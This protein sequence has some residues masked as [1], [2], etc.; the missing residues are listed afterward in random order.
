MRINKRIN[1]FFISLILVFSVKAVNVFAASIS[2]KVNSLNVNKQSAKVDETV[3]INAS[4]TGSKNL[5]YKFSIFDGTRW[6]VLQD[7]SSK[8]NTVW[9]PYRASTSKIKLE[10]KDKYSSKNYNSK[11]INYQ[12]YSNVT[13]QALSTDVK[14]TQVINAPVQVT[15]TTNLS[16]GV[17]YKYSVF[18]GQVWKTVRDYTY[19]KSMIW[20]ALKAG[21]YIIKVDVKQA[22]SL[23]NPDTSTQTSIQIV[24]KPQVQD[25]SSNVASPRKI[26]NIIILTA[27]STFGTS[28][29]YRYWVNSGTTWVKIRDYSSD[30]SY[31]WTPTEEGK[32]KIK[33]DVK[34]SKSL[35]DVDDSKEISFEILKY[36]V[37]NYVDTNLSLRGFLDSQMNLATKA[38]TWSNGNWIDATKEQASYYLNPTNFIN[39]Y[40]INQFLKLNYVDGISVEDLNKVLVGKGVLDGH[41]A[42]FLEAGKQY[43]V[44]PV[45]LVAHSLLE[46][47]NG[48]SALAKGISVK[49]IHEDFGYINSKIITLYNP[50]TVYNMYGVGAYDSNPDLWD[51]EKAYNEGWTSVSKAIIGGAKF[52]SKGYINNL[53]LKQDTLYKMRWDINTLYRSPSTLYAHQYATDIGWAYKQSVIM[54]KIIGQMSNSMFYYEI[55]RFNLP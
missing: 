17:L 10:V 13:I 51:S 41:G 38:Q 21:K 25:L 39:D 2:V 34:D 3:K 55:P 27:K 30:A 29:L 8:N 7:Y 53:T 19:N 48:T 23:R 16:S 40:G 22:N 36:G 32:Y 46:T 45:Y 4:A 11:Q 18:D 52:I 15:T 43:N 20:K 47:G 37:L 9:K 54:K 35:N 28:P 42:D 6:Y 24:D 31:S 5:V 12:V 33:V 44:N 50:V 14:V 26:G 1:I 49:S